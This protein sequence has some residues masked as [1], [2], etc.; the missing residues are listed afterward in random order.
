M[1]IIKMRTIA[2]FLL[3]LE[4]F[5]SGCSKES[6]VVDQPTGGTTNKPTIESAPSKSVDL[7]AFAGEC[8]SPG[9]SKNIVIVSEPLSGKIYLG[10]RLNQGNLEMTTISG[11]VKVIKDGY[12]FATFK[13]NG[14]VDSL[15]RFNTRDGE[16]SDIGKLSKGESSVFNK[17]CD[18]AEASEYEALLSLM[19]GG[20]ISGQEIARQNTSEEKRK[21]D[22]FNARPSKF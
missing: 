7:P 5:I 17:M 8:Y 10:S 4:I 6:K 22:E 18:K 13:P 1:R 16:L 14:A 20:Y 12:E 3:L 2:C 15:I 19:K 21:S 9:Y 11:E